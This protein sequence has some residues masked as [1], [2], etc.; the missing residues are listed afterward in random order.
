MK[1]V[2]FIRRNDHLRLESEQRQYLTASD[3]GRVIFQRPYTADSCTVQLCLQDL[4]ADLHADN[5]ATSSCLHSIQ[6]LV[7]ASVTKRL[8]ATPF[9]W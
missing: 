1:R 9:L 4:A 3:V 6:Q 7:T 2:D 5:K 8:L